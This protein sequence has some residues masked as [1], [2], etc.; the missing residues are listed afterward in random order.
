MI[1]VLLSSVAGFASGAIVTALTSSKS[2]AERR[3]EIKEEIDS[4]THDVDEVTT[5]INEVKTSFHRLGQVAK[6][7]IP[8]MKEDIEEIKTAAKF[9]LEPRIQRVNDAVNQLQTDLEHGQQ[10][11]KEN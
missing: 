5:S 9:Q 10:E 8:E 2:G 6:T 1:G 4:F 11:I 7:L 3:Q